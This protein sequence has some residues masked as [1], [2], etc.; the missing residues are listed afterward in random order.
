MSGQ[1]LISIIVVNYNSKKD[2][3]E[4]FSSL[5]QCT[6][7]NTEWIVV[8]NASKDNDFE[9]LLKQY[10]NQLKVIHSPENKGFAAANNLGVLEAKGAY[11]LFI[12]PD[13]VVNPDFLESLVTVMQR[14][15]KIGMV[16]P[17][18]KYYN[19]P[20][21]IQYAGS[22]KVNPLTMRNHSHGKNKR[23]HP[24][25]QVTK[26][27]AYGHGA[28][29]M[30]PKEVIEQVGLMD[31]RYFLYY[32]ELDWCERIRKAGFEIYYVASSLVYHK[33]SQSVQSNSYTQVFYMNRNR[34]L[35]AR[36]NHTIWQV[37][38][39]LF[40]AIFIQTPIYIYRYIN[41]PILLKAY[42]NGLR[43]HLHFV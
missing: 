22:T 5:E 15:E 18:I 3:A 41:K 23:D 42:L 25:Y 35:F 19:E 29:M 13:V 43:W 27:T 24:L 10:P 40:Y 33:V 4:L 17:K 37:M 2:L 9:A 8:D 28:A 31:E 38:A 6:Y 12:N 36:L 14:N 32:E 1:A 26:S 7:Q 20:D 11:Y 30:V 21:F 16:S 39:Y 34:I